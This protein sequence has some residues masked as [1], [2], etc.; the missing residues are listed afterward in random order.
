MV[1]ADADVMLIDEVLA[2]GDAAF[3]QKCMDVFYEKRAAGTTIVLVTHDMGS[4]QAL[5]DRA[6]LIHEGTVRHLGDPREVAMR[7]YRLN[8]DAEGPAPVADTGAEG[9]EAPPE[10]LGEDAV[11]D[12]H[13]TLVE[14]SLHDEDGRRVENVQQDHSFGID[15]LLRARRAL[16]GPVFAVYVTNADGDVIFGFHKVLSVPEGAPDALVAGQRVR[17]AG[18]I[19]NQLRPGRYTLQC[20]ISRKRQEG[21]AM[22]AL[23]VLAFVVYGGRPDFG[24]VSALEDVTATTEPPDDDG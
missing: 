7:Y 1:Q 10:V 23:P 14:A 6:M 11:L 13:M 24:V 17:I 20:W 9:L 8:F 21:L 18:R 22:Q 5:C 12:L 2:V 16:D 19:E 3:A 4:V 15:I